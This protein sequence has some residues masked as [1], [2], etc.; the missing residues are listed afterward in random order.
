MAR[1][2]FIPA[3]H[4]FQEVIGVVETESANGKDSHSFDFFVGH[5]RHELIITA[6]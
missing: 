2:Q 5:S 4:L 1:S 3:V 6:R